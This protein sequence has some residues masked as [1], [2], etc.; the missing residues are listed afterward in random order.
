MIQAGQIIN[1][2]IRAAQILAPA[3][4]ADKT[5]AGHAR[6]FCGKNAVFGILDHDAFRR[7]ATEPPGRFQKDVGSRFGVQDILPAD[8]RI[9]KRDDFE[10]GHDEVD[11]PPVRTATD[12]QSH[13]CAMKAPDQF[14]RMRD[15]TDGIPEI[16]L[17]AE[18]EPVPEIL[19]RDFQPVTLDETLEQDVCAGPRIGLQFFQC[20]RDPE[21]L[22][23]LLL[24]QAVDGLAVCDHAV[25]IK[26]TGLE[27]DTPVL[28]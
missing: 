18:P 3:V 21:W 10:M 19:Q 17:E 27:Q 7:P 12:R 28:D 4:G 24:G 16:F 1:H 15:G 9:E 2:P 11:Q 20:G 26:N 6:L 14:Q 23:R 13:A 22:Q 25:H 8:N 5:D